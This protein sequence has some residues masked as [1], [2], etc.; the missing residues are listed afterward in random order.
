MIMRR[1]LWRFIISSRKPAPGSFSLSHSSSVVRTRG[2]AI[3]DLI[4]ARLRR[5]GR[6]VRPLLELANFPA[7]RQFGEDKRDQLAAYCRSC[8]VLFAGNG[9][10]P[11]HRFT[12]TPDGESGLN[13]LCPSFK[14]FLNHINPAMQVMGRLWLEGKSAS[15]IMELMAEKDRDESCAL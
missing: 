14:K 10:C 5:A 8:E 12:K 7:Q 6:A 9:E 2:P 4:S 13:Y 1:S 15:L 3:W 11:K